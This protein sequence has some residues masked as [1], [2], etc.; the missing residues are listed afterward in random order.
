[1][2]VSCHFCQLLITE[3]HVACKSTRIY[4]ISPDKWGGGK[5]TALQDFCF[6]NENLISAIQS[7]VLRRVGEL[8]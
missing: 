5:E 7:I 8:N 2:F 4:N 6:Y 1:M 3:P